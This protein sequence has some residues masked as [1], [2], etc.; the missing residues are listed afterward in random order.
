MVERCPNAD[1]RDSGEQ[2]DSQ[3]L[4]PGIHCQPDNQTQTEINTFI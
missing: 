1:F 3:V 2:Q 4:I